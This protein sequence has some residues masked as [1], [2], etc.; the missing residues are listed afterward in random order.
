MASSSQ[1]GPLKRGDYSP[2]KSS[3]LRSPCPLVNS[4]ANHGYIPRDGRNVLAA[5]LSG[6][7]NE[8]G[9]SKALGA[10]LSRPIFLEYVER[11][12][13]AKEDANGKKG[14]FLAHLWT[15]LRN[16]RA[17]LAKAFGM[18]KPGQFDSTGK[19][20]LNLDQL[21]AHGVVEHDVSFSRRDIGQGDNLSKQADLVQQI[22]AASSDGKTITA[23]DF[24]GLRRR[25]IE[26]QK[27]A[28]PSLT[29]GAS[30]HQLACGEIALI[31]KVFGDGKKVPCD[32]MKAF[33]EEERLPREE[34]WT[35]RWW[36]VGFFDL[37][38]LAAKVKKIIVGH[39]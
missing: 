33:F 10:A 39:F 7:V 18:R 19:P 6:A 13:I 2:S 30:Q 36:S 1:P 4:L 23:E 8:V 16:P 26:E 11:A 21:A 27:K 15:F 25:R 31:L 38:P 20:C 24:A 3:D 14:S 12:S 22:I 9:I 17:A 28:N 5:E 29:Y 32:Y 34:G 35:K 37:I